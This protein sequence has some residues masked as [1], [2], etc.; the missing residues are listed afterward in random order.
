MRAAVKSVDAR[1][2]RDVGD[3]VGALLLRDPAAGVALDLTGERADAAPRRA[4]G[5]V[6]GEVAR[7]QRGDDP[8][9]QVRRGDPLEGGVRRPAGQSG[10][11][12]G[13]RAE[14]ADHLDGQSGQ[15]L[16][17]AVD[18]RVEQLLAELGEGLP[19]V[20]H[21]PLGRCVVRLALD[22]LADEGREVDVEQCLEGRPLHLP[23]DQC[24]GV[25]VPDGGPA[26][27]GEGGQR[28]DRVQV[29]GQRDRQAGAPQRL[30]EG[31]VPV[32]QAAGGHRATCGAGA[33][34]SRAPGPRRA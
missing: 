3:V 10:A 18:Q 31:D 20:A 19:V 16:L 30:E 17:V 2:H 15:L 32:D 28:G 11:A 7:Q 13:H 9:D 33:R 27:P 29:L 34:G 22:P 8:V 4:R 6:L 21:L 23:L 25:R 1:L 5:L 12:A 26:V 14:A 24:G